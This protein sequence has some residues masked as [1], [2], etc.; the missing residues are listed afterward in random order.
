MSLPLSVKCTVPVNPAAIA[1]PGLV[2]EMVAVYVMVWPETDGL[3]LEVTTGVV[4][5]ALPTV[6][7]TSS[8]EMR[9]RVVVTA[10]AGLDGVAARSQCG[11]RAA[12][13]S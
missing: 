2:I 7:M 6:W 11:R 9:V 12:D 4:V 5:S 3:W 1:A 13:G 10:V 8:D